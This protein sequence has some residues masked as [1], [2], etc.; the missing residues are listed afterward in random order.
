MKGMAKSEEIDIFEVVEMQWNSVVLWEGIFAHAIVEELPR[1][2]YG[3][4]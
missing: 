3:F 1:Y 2:G 4:H